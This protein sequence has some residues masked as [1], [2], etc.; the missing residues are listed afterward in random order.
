MNASSTTPQLPPSDSNQRLIALLEYIEQVEKLKRT[1]V[2]KVA[3]EPLRRFQSELR[4]LPGIDFDVNEA[5]DVVWMKVARLKEGMAPAL[6]EALKPW[7]DLP[8]SPDRLPTLKSE[9]VEG[10]PAQIKAANEQKRRRGRAVRAR[11]SAL[12]VED[13]PPAITAAAAEP[14]R[15]YLNDFPHLKGLLDTYI[16]EQFAPWTAGEKP[17]RQ[18]MAFYQKL[19]AQSQTMSFDGA[20]YELVWGMGF[21]V[22]TR[23]ETLEY[24]LIT[25]LCDVSLNDRT[26]ELEVRPRAISP[27][28]ELDPYV[29]LQVDGVKRLT[30][31]WRAYRD[32]AA[33]LPNPFVAATV[34]PILQTAV[35][36]LDATGCLVKTEELSLPGNQRHPQATDTLQITDTWVLFVR[37]RSAHVF[38]DDVACLK[39][40]LESAAELP[41]ALAA[42][43]NAGA[44]EV[45]VPARI[46]YR[47]LSSSG[48]EGATKPEELYFPLPYN[49]SQV[50]IVQ[51]LESSNGPG[52]TVV[53][54]PPGTGKSHT[55]AN[56]ICHYLAHGKRVLVT[57]QGE[58]ALRVLQEKIPASI[59]PLTVGLLTDERTGMQQFEASIQSI[60]ATVGALD[61]ERTQQSIE[62]LEAQLDKVHRQT[63]ALDAKINELATRQLQSIAFQGRDMLPETLARLV[64]DEEDKHQWLTDVLDWN[65][66]RDPKFSTSDISALRDARRRV[67]TDLGYL[68]AVLPAT[69]A[70][71]APESLLALHQ[72]LCRAREIQ[73]K[74]AAGEFLSLRDTSAPT[75]EQALKLQTQ[76]EATEKLARETTAEDLPWCPAV[77]RTFT[78]ANSATA[79]LINTFLQVAGEMLTEEDAR[80]RRLTRPVAAP[81]DAELDP[82]V[83]AAVNRC[84]E[85]KSPF[86]LPIG[87]SAQ[88]AL[89]N[90]MTVEELKPVSVEDWRCVAQELEHRIIARKLVSRLNA[91]ARELEIPTAEAGPDAFAQSVRI[92]RRVR[93]LVQ[94]VQEDLNCRALV[95]AV[96]GADVWSRIPDR[97]S[98]PDAA[99]QALLKSLA[100]HVTQARLMYANARLEA[101]FALL[102]DT[103]G[104]VTHRLRALLQ[105]VG[106]DASTEALKPEY[107]D[108]LVEL[109]RLH[110]LR[111]AL[112]TIDTV[113]R[114][115]AKSGASKWAKRL[116]TET[117]DAAHDLTP[118]SWTE[119][120]QWRCA[121]TLLESLAGH[122][123]LKARFDQRK[124]CEHDLS[125]LYE[126]LVAK[127][128]WLAVYRS[129]PPAVRQALQE[130]LNEIQAIGKGTGIRA[131]HHLQL[132]RA[133]MERAARAVPCWIMNQERVSESIPA[134][135][136]SF[137]LVVIDEA[138]Q[139][140]IWAL[141][142]LLRGKKLLVVGDHAQVSPA[143][144]GLEE[145]RVRDLF[146][147]YLDGIPHGSQM[148]PDRS[149]YDLARVVFAGNSVML[150][151]HF[152]CVPAIIEYS[153][154]EFYEH[155][156]TPLRIPK[157]SERLDPPLIDVFVK[158]GF[159]VGKINKPE[160][161]AIV[162]EIQAII[163]D[164]QMQGRTIGVVTLLGH[165]QAKLINDMVQKRIA[166]HEIHTRKIRVGQPAQ[167][168]GREADIVMISNVLERGDLGIPRSLANSQ[169]FNVAASRARDRMMLFRSLSE[170]D[171]NPQTLTAQLLAHFRQPFHQD[172]R[173]VERLR[174]LC[175]SDFEREVYGELT[176]KGYRV[177]PQVPVGTFRIDFV[178]EGNDNRRLAV[179]C[180]G[181]RYHGPTQWADD[182]RRQRVLERAGWTFWRTF[183]SSFVL[184]RAQ[185]LQSL[186]GTLERLG[187]EPIGSDTVDSTA[188]VEERIIDPLTED[189]SEAPLTAVRA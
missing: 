186:Y 105:G 51:C 57:S 179:E 183:A 139:S 9:I 23:G 189:P 4:G 79:A 152:R 162:D 10:E 31:W 59:R 48:H 146:A 153:K 175:E 171:V 111:P 128:A 28:L 180:D 126:Q 75:Y 7:V 188:W 165:E 33:Q 6:P 133:A 148:R 47:G 68:T 134:E 158:G 110:G 1:P 151:E 172:R 52:G 29:D 49:Q 106:S 155:A 150:K 54:G 60:A 123:E 113:T 14:K 61:P 5:G 177:K 36:H 173:Q 125:A 164:P 86:A 70:F 181:D 161:E 124:N 170:S 107:R 94:L 2:F 120:W 58:E 32:A 55:I 34:E 63:S 160:A 143:G 62:A 41:D 25:Q 145:S 88:R 80:R 142:A 103:S 114:Q 100:Q 174:D 50:D 118:D 167:F 69:D 11:L 97:K 102:V 78:R 157:S 30:E 184:Q 24:P 17:R 138:S 44:S 71:P 8:N 42:F 136:G 19:Y 77:R 163:E 37:R 81:R 109:K 116:R 95:E 169:R 43:V 56:V 166:M 74:V 16:T 140:D 132:A 21:A 72:D 104:E 84:L 66:Q 18:T 89:L 73:S 90:Q 187:I 141:P 182:M 27:V 176:A 156:I 149:I 154:R 3:V 26:Y 101:L 121:K 20:D 119:A 178:V 135:I 67:G 131:A 144:V 38:L 96:F 115:I 83:F 91:A 159:R 53:Q 82:E 45:T 92:A 127:R 122:Q 112:L 46:A 93:S 65:T 39:K 108:L 15:L 130:Y 76:L 147:R 12:L 137:H 85:G 185:V 22:W 35:A 129:S 98:D 168:Q 13:P 40:K 87:K 99:R 64:L 117:A